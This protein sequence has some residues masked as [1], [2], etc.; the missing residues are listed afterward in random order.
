MDAK[1]SSRLTQILVPVDP[2]DP[3]KQWRAMAVV[4]GA[5]E[6][7]GQW[8]CYRLGSD[9]VAGRNVIKYQAT[10]AAGANGL[11]LD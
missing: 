2:N 1:Q 7:A 9:S 11:R 6:Q 8:Y 10:I 3:C 4:A 5:A